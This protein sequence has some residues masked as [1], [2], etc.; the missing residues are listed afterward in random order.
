M[1][2]PMRPFRYMVEADES[3]VRRGSFPISPA[4]SPRAGKSCYLVGGA[5]RDY[6]LGRDVSDFDVATDARPEEVVRLFRRVIPTGIKHGTVTVTL[7]GPSAR[8]HDLQD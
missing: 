5:L 4:C 3:D 6:L 7:Q 2:L 1:S 8:G